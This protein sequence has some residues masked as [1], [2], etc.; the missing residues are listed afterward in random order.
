MTLLRPA[1]AGLAALALLA[2]CG[3]APEP[4]A[5]EAAPQTQAMTEQGPVI[6]FVHEAGAHVW[7]GVPYAAA[8]VGDLRW[9]A[10]RPAPARAEPLQALEHPAWC[11]QITSALDQGYGLDPNILHGDEDCLYLNVYAPPEAQDLPVMVWIHGGANVWGRAA[12]YDGANLALREN[13]VVVVV[14]YRLGPLGWFSHPALRDAAEDFDDAAANFALL[15]LAQSLRWVNANIAAFGGDP[16]RVTIFGESAGGHNVAGLLTMPQAAG[17][18]HGAIIQ[19]GLAATVSIDAAEGR[20]PGQPNPSGV[21]AEAI[22]GAEA[23]ADQLRAVA[24]EDLFAAY[25]PGTRPME[26]PRMIADGVTVPSE[27]IQAAMGVPGRF[28]PVPVITGTNRDETKLF[29]LLNPAHTRR[30]LGVFTLA[31]DQRMYDLHA[32]YESRA[33][34]IEAVDN[35]AAALTGAGHD[36]VYAY[37]FD[38]D[39]GGRFLISDYGRLFGAAHALEIPFV[40]A[41][42]SFMGTAD[43]VLF[44]RGNREGREALSRAMTGY[45][46]EFARSGEPGNG[47][48]EQARWGRWGAGERMLLD[49][50]AGGGTRMNQGADS[51]AALAEDLAGDGRMNDSERCAVFNS[52]ALWFASFEPYRARINGGACAR[53]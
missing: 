37:R 14:Q 8:P 36:A 30:I 21:I 45:W 43:R 50:P 25:R 29:N 34:K 28:H 7:R 19:S 10:P 15:D 26:L 1:L 32:E 12:Q 48:G 20:E 47:G 17:L 49:S 27:G 52:T 22:A 2:A 41:R 46:A 5:P 18:F 38:W 44:T 51:F 3:R 31:R 13:V 53:G 11:P 4:V 23:T 9:R 39:E 42:F 24:L 33:W 40:F 35:I 6:G 16:G